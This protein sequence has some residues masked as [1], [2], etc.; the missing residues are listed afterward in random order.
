MVARWYF[1]QV[2]KIIISKLCLDF[3]NRPSAAFWCH[4]RPP[5]GVLREVLCLKGLKQERGGRLYR[6]SYCQRRTASDLGAR[7]RPERRESA[8][9]CRVI[10]GRCFVAG[11]LTTRSFSL[12]ILLWCLAVWEAAKL[13]HDWTPY[14]MEEVHRRRQDEDRVQGYWQ[15]G[16]RSSRYCVI[17]SLDRSSYFI[18]LLSGAVTHISNVS[19]IFVLFSWL[20]L[21]GGLC[22]RSG[23]SSSLDRHSFSVVVRLA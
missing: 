5:G 20:D 12:S 16:C 14:A 4:V 6:S 22:I 17:H 11:A 15:F 23:C 21:I 19:V 10:H 7:T 2:C 13:R 1:P 3:G 8:R 9:A 18:I